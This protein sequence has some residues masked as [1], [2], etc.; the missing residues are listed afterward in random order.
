MAFLISW[1]ADASFRGAPVAFYA[2]IVCYFVAFAFM[3]TA[4]HDL[5]D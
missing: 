1:L 4:V 3:V 5:L 2:A